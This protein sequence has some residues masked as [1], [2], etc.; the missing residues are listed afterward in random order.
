M[1][2][3][4]SKML[5][6]S[7]KSSGSSELSLRWMFCAMVGMNPHGIELEGTHTWKV[8]VEPDF[9]ACHLE[10]EIVEVD[11]GKCKQNVL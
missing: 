7:A 2:F 4:H 5:L 3:K 11:L 10:A 8:K 1:C 9:S 6:T